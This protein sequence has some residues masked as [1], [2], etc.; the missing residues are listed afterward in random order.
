MESNERGL[1][2]SSF[3]DGQRER[4]RMCM[5][6]DGHMVRVVLTGMSLNLSLSQSFTHVH[7]Y[8]SQRRG[9]VFKIIWPWNN[10]DFFFLQTSQSLQFAPLFTFNAFF[11]LF[12]LLAGNIQKP[13]MASTSKRDRNRENGGKTRTEAI[14]KDAASFLCTSARSTSGRSVGKMWFLA[15]TSQREQHRA[16][17]EESKWFTG[18]GRVERLQRR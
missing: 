6:V 5:Y 3:W 16:R 18:A 13:A 11:I 9:W 8:A 12:Y 1:S 14:W 15:P 10:D 7:I 17:E 4:E 2:Y